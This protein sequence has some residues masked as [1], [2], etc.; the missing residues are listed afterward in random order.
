MAYSR[1][2]VDLVHLPFGSH[3]HAGHVKTSR[4]SI[5]TIRRRHDLLYTY[6]C[7]RS[8]KQSRRQNISGYFA[9]KDV[10]LEISRTFSNRCIEVKILK[11]SK[12][13]LVRYIGKATNLTMFVVQDNVNSKPIGFEQRTANVP[14]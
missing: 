4:A 13:D 3:A 7:D 11:V 2:E 5:G 8:W 9:S 1:L 10:E 14:F 12:I 6:I